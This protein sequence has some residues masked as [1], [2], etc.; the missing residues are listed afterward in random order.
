MR[1]AFVIVGTDTEVGKTVF[2]AALADALGAHYWKPVQSGLEDETDSQTVAR[3]GGLSPQRIVPEAWRLTLPA[4]PNIAARAEGV[5]IDVARLAPPQG[6]TPLVI[7]TAGGVM[8]PLTDNFITV[9][10]LARW[11]LPAIV[12]SRTALGAIN[13]SLLTL[14]ALRS[15]RVPVH[16]L[17]F[18]GD[19]YAMAQRSIERLGDVRI[20]GRLPRLD[21]LNRESLR[22]A[23][24]AGFSL[25]DFEI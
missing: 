4:S 11:G 5:E 16:G 20:L 25:R 10:L 22:A 3:L 6:V 12:V 2:S 19:E 14:E 18:V 8:V 15:R 23:F 7:E 17:A 13:H 9:D 1:R 21:P 24:A